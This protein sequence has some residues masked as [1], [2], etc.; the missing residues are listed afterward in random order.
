MIFLIPVIVVHLVYCLYNVNWAPQITQK[1]ACRTLKVP[2]PS[3]L[4][5]VNKI[6]KSKW[7][8]RET[9]AWLLRLLGKKHR[10]GKKRS[11]IPMQK[12]E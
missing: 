9:E 12:E 7:L 3:W 8:G 6:A 4:C 2:D 10:K 5:L 11:R 1:F